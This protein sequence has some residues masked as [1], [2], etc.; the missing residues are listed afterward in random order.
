[1]AILSLEA[2]VSINNVEQRFTLMI[3]ARK[4]YSILNRSP[5]IQKMDDEF[6]Q[7]I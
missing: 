7:I 3:K 1:M 6:I 5:N 4:Y 2:E